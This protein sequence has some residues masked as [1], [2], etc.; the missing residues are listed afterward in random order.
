[1]RTK[2]HSACKSNQSL[3]GDKRNPK[4]QGQNNRLF[5]K[6]NGKLEPVRLDM[7]LMVTDSS[8]RSVEISDHGFPLC[9]LIRV[10]VCVF[11][12]PERGQGV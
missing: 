9:P 3:V 7:E 2:S 6:V 8:D 4:K 10:P 12:V 11:P 1:M 5:R